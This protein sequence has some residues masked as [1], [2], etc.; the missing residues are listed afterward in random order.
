MAT[1]TV[2]ISEVKTKDGSGAKGAWTL[3]ALIDGNGN[4]HSTFDRALGTFLQQNVGSLVD[5]ETEQGAKGSDLKSARLHA[6]EVRG[7][8]NTGNRETLIAREV[9]LKA[10]VDWSASHPEASWNDIVNVADK[11]TTWITSQD[12]GPA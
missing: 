3:Y 9:A 12:E 11:F 2:K 1:S 8:V 7:A 5:I 6:E 10:A 4:R